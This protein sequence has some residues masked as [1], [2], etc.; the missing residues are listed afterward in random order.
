MT[1]ASQ[2]LVPNILTHMY[3][4]AI[5]IYNVIPINFGCWFLG[6]LHKKRNDFPLMFLVVSAAND[7][8]LEYLRHDKIW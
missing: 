8:A 7:M 1:K 2:A 5:F 4:T 3:S 6:T